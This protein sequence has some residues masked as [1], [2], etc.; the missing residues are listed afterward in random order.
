MPIQNIEE[1]P[2]IKK[3]L[4]AMPTMGTMPIKT[5]K[6]L[7]GILFRSKCEFFLQFTENS[8]IY[9][10]RNDLAECAMEKECDYVLWIDS[11]M[12]FPADALERM[13][14]DDKDVVTGLYFQRRGEHRPVIY[15]KVDETGTEL[16]NDYPQDHLFM[17]EGCGFGLV[18]M[19]VEVLRRIAEEYHLMFHP[20][21]QL[22]EDLSFCYR[23]K[24]LGGEIWC[25]PAIKCGHL[26]E[27]EFT[28]EDYWHGRRA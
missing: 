16:V 22:G 3:V 15:S 11:D 23:W 18:L 27:Y 17:V 21:P 14:A 4:I 8:L 24:E 19:R 12:T 10:A 13:I 25:D 26:G 9:N 28:E 1:V 2:K 7:M 6:S 5:V 20:I